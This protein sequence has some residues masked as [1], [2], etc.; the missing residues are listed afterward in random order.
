MR[1]VPNWDPVN[2]H[3]SL[4]SSPLYQNNLF[5]LK[6]TLQSELYLQDYRLIDYC[7]TIKPELPGTVHPP[8]AFPRP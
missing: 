2:R 1:L 4:H 6:L 7:I 8:Q 3:T 5:Y